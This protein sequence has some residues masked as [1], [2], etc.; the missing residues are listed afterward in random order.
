MVDDLKK[1]YI[2]NCI[3]R[4]IASKCSDRNVG[5]RAEDITSAI[6]IAQDS[7][8]AAHEYLIRLCDEAE[9]GKYAS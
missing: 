8:K 7:L 3:Q 1:F 5:K 9:A 6:H 4:I 2:S